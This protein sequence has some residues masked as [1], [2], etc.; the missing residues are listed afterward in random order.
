MVNDNNFRKISKDKY[1]IAGIITFLIFSL[2]LTL[3]FILED[4]RYNLIEEV[5][6]KQNVKFLSIQL[7][8]QF[9][10]SFSNY[11]DCA[12]LDTTLSEAVKELDDSLKVVIDYEE[13]NE[14]ATERKIL[15]QRRYVIDNLRYWLTA[16]ES[17]EKCDLDIVSIIYFS[18]KECASCPVQGT[19]LTYYKKIF[20]EKVLVFPINLDLR[21]EEPMVEIIRSHF[22]VTKYPTLIIDNKKY[23]GV[24]KSEQ[25]KEII[26]SS[27]KKAPECQE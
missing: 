9:L 17:K 8:Y 6:M 21:E 14:A 24:I 27:L 19:I 10:N 22:N 4:H 7:Q 11:N 25:M 13:N 5:N 20:G 23:E 18:S 3:G 12:V 15:V 1:V 2:G 26:C 16:R